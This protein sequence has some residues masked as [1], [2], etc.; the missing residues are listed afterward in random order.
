MGI[1]IAGLVIAAISALSSVIQAREAAREKHAEL[2]A[3]Q[4]DTA[5]QVGPPDLES[6]EVSVLNQVIPPDLLQT[7]EEN[8]EEAINRLERALKDPANSPQ[9]RDQEEAIA[10]SII[11]SE[12]A[13]IRR[14]ND[15]ALPGQLANLWVVFKCG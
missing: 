1:E 13:R 12:L 2:T 11:C 14:L 9:T 7:M 6:S 3:E 4:I 15:E 8:I 10:K 5:L